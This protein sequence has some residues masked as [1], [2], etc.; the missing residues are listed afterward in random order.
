MMLYHA[1]LMTD[2]FCLLLWR[3]LYIQCRARRG[4]LGHV[5]RVAVIH[6]TVF[7]GKEFQLRKHT[8]FFDPEGLCG[9]KACYLLA[10]LI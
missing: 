5:S 9:K 10:D 2:V 7:K 8:R 3:Q 1:V 4:G 6:G